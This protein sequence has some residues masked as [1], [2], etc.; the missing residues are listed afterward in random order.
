MIRDDGLLD[1]LDRPGA[2][3]G[4]HFAGPQGSWESWSYQGLAQLTWQAAAGLRRLGA[5]PGDVVAIVQRA[6]PQF[7]ATYFGALAAGAAACSIAPPFAFQRS[8]DYQRHASHLLATARPR[9]TVADGDVLGPLCEPSAQAGISSPVPFAALTGTGDFATAHQP[10]AGDTALLQFTSG[11]TGRPR[12]VRVTHGAASAN[13][14]AIRRWLDW[15]PD[16]AGASWLP[17]HHDM[18][19][20][21]LLAAVVSGCDT[22]LMQPEDF[23]R[24]PLRYLSCLSEQRVAITPLAN[25]GLAYILRRVRPSDLA[26]LRFDALKAVII[27]AER[28]DPRVLG[29]AEKVLGPFGLD[30]RALL[31]AYGSAEATLAITCLPPGEGW[32]A[33]PPPGRPGA[34]ASADGP[35]VVGCGRPVQGV[36][37]RIVGADGSLAPDGTEGDIVVESTGLASG[38]YGDAGT[39]SA[40]S[41]GRGE[42]RTGDAGFMADGQ[43]FVLGRLGDGM[44][45][46]GQMVFAESIEAKLAELGIPQRRVAVLLGHRDGVPT[47]ALAFEVADSDWLDIAARV[48]RELVAGAEMIAVN[49]PRGGLAVTSSGKLRRRVMWQALCDG[50]L[51]GEAI[52]LSGQPADRPALA[53]AP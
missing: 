31:P 36:T 12:C 39:A 47:A 45:V 30:R 26:G 9:V 22:W 7:L 23:I 51:G 49:L 6:S 25:F 11:S 20:I 42:L 8:D 4:L 50:T 34:P 38:Y 10:A 48:L 40:T 44:K 27:G 32:T 13:I 2:G 52:A 33:L 21:G 46:R 14:T 28:I 19:L 41:L 43:L 3:R 5:G 17:V 37:V 16:Q 15:G 24:S 29:S 35:Q 1:W 53:V 18:G